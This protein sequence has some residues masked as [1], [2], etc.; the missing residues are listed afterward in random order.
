MQV[1]A[2]LH[3]CD[4]RLDSPASRTPVPQAVLT[5][6][7]LEVLFELVNAENKLQSLSG[8]KRWQ[9]R[10]DPFQ[11]NARARNRDLNLHVC[12]AVI[13]RRYF[14]IQRRSGP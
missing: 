3:T 14:G 12:F 10:C 7:L 5:L 6:L 1:R 11:P 2:E 4:A 9:A 8:H 13:D